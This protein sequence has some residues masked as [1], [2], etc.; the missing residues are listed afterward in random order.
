MSST[1]VRRRL[2]AS[3]LSSA[4]AIAGLGAAVG[5]SDAAPAA[6]VSCATAWGSLPKATSM[7]LMTR[8]VV[9]A[10]RAGQHACYDRFVI[11]IGRGSG[12]PGYRVR[13]VSVATGIGSGLPVR[14]TGG[15][16]IEILVNAPASSTTHL[17]P[18]SGE[19]FR[20]FR[21]LRQVKTTGSFE[22]QTGYALGV[23]ARLPMRAFLLVHPDGTRVLVVDVAHTW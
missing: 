7:T 21:T 20:G 16:V 2:S 12:T 15:A 5:V 17:P 22:G 9:Q 10:D 13:Y 11:D 8:G 23:R 19:N 18:A 4:L 1:T 6:A 14:V 3:I